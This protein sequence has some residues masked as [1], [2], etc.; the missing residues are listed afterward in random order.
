MKW[1]R[2]DENDIMFMQIARRFS[3]MLINDDE[4][5]GPNCCFKEF[6]ILENNKTFTNLPY[7][8]SRFS[9]STMLTTKATLPCLH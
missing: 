1:A 2:N 9:L 6:P 7:L 8:K 4:K 3:Q 5:F